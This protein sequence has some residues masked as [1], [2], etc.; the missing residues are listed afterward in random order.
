MVV[1]DEKGESIKAP[2]KEQAKLYHIRATCVKII[3]TGECDK[4][5]KCHFGHD[6]IVS[7]LA[8]EERRAD[9]GIANRVKS[10]KEGAAI[11]AKVT[12]ERAAREAAAKE[13]RE[14]AKMEKQQHIGPTALGLTS[15]AQQLPR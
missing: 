13:E 6:L 11:Q 14:A 2:C 8:V 12:A 15:T 10:A 4:R 9:E 7:R 1:P 3:K 5:D